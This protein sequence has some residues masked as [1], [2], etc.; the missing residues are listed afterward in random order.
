MNDTNKRLLL[1]L[2]IAAL[3]LPA[4]YAYL[5]WNR[6]MVWPEK[7]AR[8]IASLKDPSSSQF[9]NEN[10]PGEYLCGEMNSKN[11][12][13]GYVGFARYIAF[14]H[15]FAIE[16]QPVDTF[17]SKDENSRRILDDLDRDNRLHRQFLDTLRRSPK[18]EEYNV[19]AFS[20]LWGTY[21][22]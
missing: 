17:F 12:M 2:A 6:W 19:N 13:G 1:A 14:E 20:E 21:C 3:L 11:S 4:V 10:M 8:L 22:K 5:N 7:K 16:G 9:R 15:G 18:A